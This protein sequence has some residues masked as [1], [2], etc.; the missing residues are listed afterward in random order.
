MIFVSHAEHYYSAWLLYLVN[1][2][3][4]LWGHLKHCKGH[5]GACLVQY[6]VS[7]IIENRVLNSEEYIIREMGISIQLLQILQE[8]KISHTELLACPL[9]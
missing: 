1:G 9:Q 5:K 2:A 6:K 4:D 3:L 8:G 7:A